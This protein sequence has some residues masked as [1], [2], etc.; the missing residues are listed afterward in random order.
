MKR[1]FILAKKKI[2]FY[3]S[4]ISSYWDFAKTELILEVQRCVRDWDWSLEEDGNME[5]KKKI[6]LDNGMAG[7]CVHTKQNEKLKGSH[8][9]CKG[10]NKD[11]LTIRNT[12]F[13][14]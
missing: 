7:A 8:I 11:L 13:F 10:S 2:E 12:K 4:W 6:L 3:L 14:R 5:S 9:E 1:K